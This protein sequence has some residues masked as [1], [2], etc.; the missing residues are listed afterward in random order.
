[1]QCTSDTNRI[2]LEL[3]IMIILNKLGH[4]NIKKEVTK[5]YKD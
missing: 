1:M 4:T 3:F 5:A 2:L